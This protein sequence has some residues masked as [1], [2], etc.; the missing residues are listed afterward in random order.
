M[1][2]DLQPVCA[3]EAFVSARTNR[4]GQRRTNACRNMD[5]NLSAAQHFYPWNG[6]ERDSLTHPQENGMLGVQQLRRRYLKARYVECAT[7]QDA[8]AAERLEKALE[9]PK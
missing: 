3:E 9:Q 7:P 8:A 6:R 5:E 1:V 4:P 2:L